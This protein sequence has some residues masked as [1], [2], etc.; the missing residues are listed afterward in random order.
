MRTGWCWAGA[1]A[2]AALL[3]ASADGRAQPAGPFDGFWMVDVSCAMG[4]D[5]AAP[6]RWHFPAE[7]RGGAVRGQR[8]QPG[9]PNSSTL[10]GRIAPNGDA[11][12]T[13]DGLTG[14]PEY[15]VGRVAPG[16]PFHH[17]VVAHFA[18]RAGSGIAHGVRDCTY[19]FAKS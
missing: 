3:A 18:G 15:S 13:N 5:G 1:A 9:Q 14:P 10:A 7:V 12:I 11:Q 2:L 19:A 16:Y 8:G 4:R 6:Y 17:D